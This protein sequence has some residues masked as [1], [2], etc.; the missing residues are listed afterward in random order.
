MLGNGCSS[1]AFTKEGS[2]LWL[3]LRSS[4][5]ARGYNI[6]VSTRSFEP[7]YPPNES[8]DFIIFFKW[9]TNLNKELLQQY[10]KHK[11]I[12]LVYDTPIFPVHQ[13][14]KTLAIFGK[15]LTYNKDLIDNKKFFYMVPMQARNDFDKKQSNFFRYWKKGFNAKKLCVLVATYW[16]S[17]HPLELYRA[18][19]QL[20][21][22]F[23]DKPQ[24]FDLYGRRW[25]DEFKKNIKSEWVNNKFS[26][27]NKYKFCI[28]YENATNKGYISEKIFDCF[29]AGC[30][31]IYLGA[32]DI[33]DFVPKNCFINRRRFK[34]NTAL[35]HY[36]KNIKEEEYNEYLSNIRKYL[37]TDSR[38]ELF[39]HEAF[40]NTILEALK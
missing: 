32:P 28:A 12:Y 3:K 15:V 20:I 5:E 35:Y 39:T 11:L 14:P 16:E 40:I 4:L 36:I 19:K 6:T 25:T 33:E 26:C 34:N 22:F 37:L 31:P 7:V 10:P 38:A 1:K 18:R 9:N 13:D 30:V 17:S 2:P 8:I 21:K 23:D 24:D 29:Y 27:I